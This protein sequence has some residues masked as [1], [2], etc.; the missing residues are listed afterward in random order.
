MTELSRESKTKTASD[1]TAFTTRDMTTRRTTVG[2][3]R[4]K[5][6]DEFD[7]EEDAKE[8]Q[9]RIASKSDAGSGVRR[10][11][12]PRKPLKLKGG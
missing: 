8:V 5:M 7:A 12:R 10:S 11:A 2:T 1:D 9:Q 6:L 3:T 4:A